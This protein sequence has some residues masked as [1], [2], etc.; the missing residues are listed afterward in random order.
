[1][2]C[3]VQHHTEVHTAQWKTLQTNGRPSYHIDSTIKIT[4]S[5]IRV[6]LLPFFFSFPV[7]LRFRHMYPVSTLNWTYIS[8][9]S[10][11]SVPALKNILFLFIV[12]RFRFMFHFIFFSSSCQSHW[13]YQYT[14]QFVAPIE[15]EMHTCWYDFQ[16]CVYAHKN[17]QENEK[18]KNSGM[19]RKEQKKCSKGHE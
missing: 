4:C 10:S 1:M 13:M 16:F 6:R 5:A 11:L 15:R 17:V 14:N 7:H 12:S 18:K 9:S 19:R 3:I 8:F 2:Y